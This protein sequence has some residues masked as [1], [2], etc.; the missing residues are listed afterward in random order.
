MRRTPLR[1]SLILAVTVG[2]LLA[3]AVVAFAA[4]VSATLQLPFE[5]APGDTGWDFG[6]MA[7]SVT[8]ANRAIAIDGTPTIAAEGTDTLVPMSYFGYSFNGSEFTSI[9]ESPMRAFSEE[10]IYSFEASGSL[11]STSYEATTG[12]YFGIDRTRPTSTSDLA[13]VYDSVATITIT[14]TDTLSGP[15]DIVYSVD[16]DADYAQQKSHADTLS[17]EVVVTAPGGHTLSWFTVDNAGNFEHTHSTTFAVNQTGYVPVLGKPRISLRNRVA[18]FAGSVTAATARKTV[19][20]TVRRLSGG[21][22]RPFA[23]YSVSVPRYT[24]SYSLSKRISKAGAYRVRASED[25]GVSSWSKGFR[26][27]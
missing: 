4:P 24:S 16:G 3:S 2:V 1:A 14:A 21:V 25:A 13:P 11:E 20:L 15:G 22:W 23:T 18:T 10:G 7:S 5:A 26:I 19:S 9:T 12:P 6:N 17:A 8:W 27:R